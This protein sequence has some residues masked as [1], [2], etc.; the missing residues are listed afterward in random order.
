MNMRHLPQLNCSW[1]FSVQGFSSAP[2]PKLTEEN[3]Q[4][5]TF[6]FCY[7]AE[8][9]LATHFYFRKLLLTQNTQHFALF[10]GKNIP[11]LLEIQQNSP[12]WISLWIKSQSCWEGSG[13]RLSEGFCRILGNNMK[14]TQ[15]EI[16][17]KEENILQAL[18]WIFNK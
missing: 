4:Y 16:H 11:I 17:P 10:H 12:V 2:S 15:P 14:I 18:A 8:C 13:K 6:Q 5:S 3:S 7:G 9:R 1:K